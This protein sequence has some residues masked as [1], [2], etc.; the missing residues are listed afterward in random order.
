MGPPGTTAT[1][2]GNVGGLG[3]NSPAPRDGTSLKLVNQ[4]SNTGAI[5]GRDAVAERPGPVAVE[6][7]GSLLDLVRQVQPHRPHPRLSQANF[8]SSSVDQRLQPTGATGNFAAA[9]PW[10]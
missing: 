9:I 3:F 8:V 5:T 2:N 6:P 1:T 10:H 4:Y 7:A